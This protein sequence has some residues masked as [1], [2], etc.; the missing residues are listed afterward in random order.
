MRNRLTESLNRLVRWCGQIVVWPLFAVALLTPVGT[1]AVWLAL[2]SPSNALI[3]LDTWP[4]QEGAWLV[5]A[6][7]YI[8]TLILLCLALR[9]IYPRGLPA[10][11][12]WSMFLSAPLCIVG[13][14]TIGPMLTNLSAKHMAAPLERKALVMASY[15]T[16][17]SF[18]GVRTK[19]YW[20]DLS[21]PLKPDQV[22]TLREHKVPRELRTPGRPIC[23]TVYTGLLGDSW[24][25]Q[26][27]TCPANKN[28]EPL[29]G[30]A[31]QLLQPELHDH[32]HEANVGTSADGLFD[33]SGRAWWL[34][35]TSYGLTLLPAGKDVT[36]TKSFECGR[37]GNPRIS[38]DRRSIVEFWNR[39][40]V[41]TPDPLPIPHWEKLGRN[42]TLMTLEGDELCRTHATLLQPGWVL[43]A[44]FDHSSQQLAVLWAQRTDASTDLAYGVTIYEVSADGSTQVTSEHALR[45]NPHWRPF[46]KAA[47]LQ[48]RPPGLVVLHDRHQRP[49]WEILPTAAS[50]PGNEDA[51]DKLMLPPMLGGLTPGNWYLAAEA[52]DAPV[53]VYRH[54]AYAGAL[55]LHREQARWYHLSTVLLPPSPQP[56]EADPATPAEADLFNFSNAR[57]S[58]SPDGRRLIACG[59]R[60]VFANSRCVLLGL[61]WPSQ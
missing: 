18:K 6:V 2:D 17:T 48:W 26:L 61:P 30:T 42:V 1:A 25:T 10:L 44:D 46:P 54:D 34:R 43:D 23:M 50:M 37:V 31:L 58:L 16:T 27:R 47:R 59:A 57:M 13:A 21:H 33:S 22:L 29:S 40:A 36:W 14:S 28:V 60:Y 49:S 53:S 19:H 12:F 39:N 4:F 24:L 20:V 41:G 51:H 9:V 35:S 56:D 32:A 45:D 15:S 5:Y 11:A 38:T 55:V 7:A 8:A 52:R 3:Q